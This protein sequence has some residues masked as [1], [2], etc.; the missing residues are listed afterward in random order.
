MSALRAQSQVQKAHFK[1]PYDVGSW[2]FSSAAERFFVLHTAYIYKLSLAS[3]FACAS[4]VLCLGVEQ[5]LQAL[6]VNTA[7][8]KYMYYVLCES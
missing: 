3:M 6:L 1:S 4:M 5:C 7:L 8:H 2:R